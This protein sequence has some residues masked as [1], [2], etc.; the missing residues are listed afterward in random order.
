[1]AEPRPSRLIPLILVVLVV[2]GA[3]TGAGFLYEYN[4]PKSGSPV[5]TVQIGDNVTVNYIGEF[6]SGPQTGRTFD[7]SLYSVARDNVNFPKS[8]EFSMRSEA[9]Y[10]PLP[11]HVGASGSYS[12]GG[13][14]FGTVVT[15]FWQGLV[16]LRAN[17]TTWISIPPSQGYGS[18]N[19][20]CFRYAPLQSTV[21]TFVTMN[22]T[23]F[24]KS[25]P[26]VN[27][28]V[29]TSFSD[30]LYGWTDTIYSANASAVVVQNLPVLDW[31]IPGTTWPVVVTGINATSITLTNR[32]TAG[33]VGQ[34]AG[35][36]RSG[37]SVCGSSQ[38]LVSSLNQGNATYTQD[39]NHEVV[40]ETLVFQ[41]TVVRF[42]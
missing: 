34:V 5:L 27:P 12:I 8:A 40:G 23:A 19:P 39:F 15:G 25:Y 22:A 14:T 9:N 20:A 41:V 30:P 21:P 10:T 36:L 7:T 31:S 13:L 42:Y 29:G 38:F 33:E 32:L 24:A 26:N 35:T 37:S 6:G 28:T 1:M 16:G 11:V 4:H 18:P 17:Q 3:G 2:A